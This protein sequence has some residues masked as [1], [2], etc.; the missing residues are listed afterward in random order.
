MSTILI[1][2]AGGFSGRHALRWLRSQSALRV[3]GFGR[4]ECPPEAVEWHRGD[5]RVAD[6]IRRAVVAVQPDYILHLAASV[7]PSK[8]GE[9]VDINVTGTWQLLSACNALGKPCAVLIVGSAASFGEMHPGESGLGG[10]RA[11]APQ[12]LYGF[13]R[14]WQLDLAGLFAQT[15]GLRIHLCRPFNLCGPGLPERHAPGALAGRLLRGDFPDGRFP[16]RNAFSVRD[17]VDVRDA[18]AAFWSILQHGRVMF[19]YSI[20]SG[21]GTT[22]GDLV[23]L[24]AEL[25]GRNVQIQPLADEK[26]NER[27]AI[28]RSVADIRDL[29]QHTGWEPRVSLRQSLQEMLAGMQ[30]TTATQTERKQGS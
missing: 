8:A 23:L 11:A 16:L 4:G 15:P 2:G 26:P 25:C 24:L 18:V 5:I 1:T 9:L 20:G 6:D 29:Q 28:I 7:D 22:V 21:I 10:S 30:D 17:L 13:S 12:G 19:P 27:S 3:A 14:Q